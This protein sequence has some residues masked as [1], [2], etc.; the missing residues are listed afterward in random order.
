MLLFADIPFFG[1]E[2]ILSQ[3]GAQ[4]GDPCVPLFFCFGIDYVVTNLISEFAV[5]Y[6]DDGTIA[7][8]PEN[9]LEDFTY[10]INEC[11]KIGLKVN[12]D[13]CELFFCSKIDAIITE[14][15][16]LIS[17]GIKIIIELAL[18]GAPITENAKKIIFEKKLFN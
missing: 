11:S 13:K 1:E 12:A 2:I 15:F 14:Q 16:K 4:Q 18:L 5:F 8:N 6:L 3:S 17:P 10:V 7:E 9:V